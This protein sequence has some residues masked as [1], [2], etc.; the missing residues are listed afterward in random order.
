[1]F[2]LVLSANIVCPCMSHAQTGWQWGLG[3][4]VYG[5]GGVAIEAWPTVTDRDGNVFLSGIIS[6]AADSARFGT[7]SI[8]NPGHY[9]QLV[10]VKADTGGHYMWA[11]GTQ[12][13][14]V[15]PVAMATDNAGC[16][17][18]VGTYENA[19]CIIGAD[20]LVDTAWS[21]MCFLAKLSPAGSVLWAINIA[22]QSNGA[23]LGVDASGNT[24]VTGSFKTSAINIG[25]IVL[26][27][28]D[29]ACNT[30]GTSGTTDVFV[31]RYATDGS[32]LWA[33]S[34][35]G[36]STDYP[37]A[38]TVSPNGSIYAA[39]RFFSSSMLV[40]G[41]TLVDTY[42]AS[43]IP[44]EFMVKYDSLGNNLWASSLNRHIDVN[45]M[46]CDGAD[47]VFLGGSVDTG[48]IIGT[49]TLAHFGGKDAFV[50][51]CNPAGN[52]VWARSAGGNDPDVVNSITLDLCGNL[53]MSGQ[54]GTI[55]GLS[56]YTM[57]FSGTTLYQPVTGY[58]PMF[59]ALYNT[60]G[61]YRTS[62]A[63][64]SGGDDESGIAVDNRGHFYVGGDFLTEMEFGPD[65]LLPSGG[66]A[67]FIG[68]YKYDS[69][70]CHAATALN[71]NLAATETGGHFVLFPN[72]ANDEVIIRSETV[73]PANANAELYDLTGRLIKTIS[74]SGKT[75]IFSVKQIVSGLYY[76]RISTGDGQVTVKKLAVVK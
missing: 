64:P 69:V 22:P 50:A 33:S 24:C 71:V 12:G 67:A 26:T 23:G 36:D 35:G 5:T 48:I 75:I 34:F 8:H 25:G 57:N 61:M 59:I 41:T 60:W 56:G 29:P 15:F 63:L 37:G 65:V 20:T 58:D 28:H 62:I 4:S 6:A 16:I 21:F 31:A 11:L 55:I 72:P 10:V 14:N 43:A 1:M 46:V 19:R 13:T 47:N 76:C 51:R 32:P 2:I 53:W 68:K 54:M 7:Y 73:F 40:S 44:A 74:L 9:S 45:A 27:N 70:F 30:S 49:D 3:S 66:E 18:V 52:I 17:F 38:L 39:G 42:A